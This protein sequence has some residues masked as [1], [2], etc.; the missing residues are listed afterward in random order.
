MQNEKKSMEYIDNMKNHEDVKTVHTA[1]NL[2]RKQEEY[3][4]N[5]KKHISKYLKLKNKI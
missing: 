5:Y 2:I 1:Y 4:D 3:H